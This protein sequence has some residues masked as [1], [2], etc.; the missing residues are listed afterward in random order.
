MTTNAPTDNTA[1]IDSGCTSNFLSAAAPC[2]DKK[3]AHAPL[4]VNM[5]NGTTI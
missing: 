4:N 3:A 5:P 2:C 1:I